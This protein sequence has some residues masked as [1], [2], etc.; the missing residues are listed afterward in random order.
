M[1]RGKYE[2]NRWNASF[3]FKICVMWTFVCFFFICTIPFS[4]GGK[5]FGRVVSRSGNHGRQP[6]VL[7][8]CLLVRQEDTL[9]VICTQSLYYLFNIAVQSSSVPFKTVLCRMLG[10]VGLVA[11]AEIHFPGYRFRKMPTTLKITSVSSYVTT[12]VFASLAR[13]APQICVSKS[14]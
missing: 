13:C 7:F 2:P 12:N 9:V 5:F 11:S 14:R 4:F 3:S 1:D 6:V 10:L 8:V